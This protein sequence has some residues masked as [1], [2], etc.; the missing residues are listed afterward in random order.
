MYR[1]LFFTLLLLSC[2]FQTFGQAFSMI[3]YGIEDGLPSN[4]VN[5]I[6]RDSKGLLWFATDNGLARYNGTSFKVWTTADGLPCNDILSFQEDLYG[7]LWIALY[8]GELCYYK[9][10][11]FH[12]AATDTLLKKGFRSSFIINFHLQRDSSIALT[13]AESNSF[14]IFKNETKRTYTLPSTVISE[15]TKLPN[16]SLLLKDPLSNTAMLMDSTGRM[17]N[18]QK[19]KVKSLRSCQNQRYFVDSSNIFDDAGNM[20]LSYRKPGFNPR[21]LFRIYRS[22]DSTLFIASSAGLYIS[23]QTI[24]FRE[25]IIYSITQDMD[26]DYWVT[27]KNNG[28]YEIKNWNK[29]AQTQVNAYTRSC[30]HA[31]ADDSNLYFT[32]GNNLY[33]FSGTTTTCLL[34]LHHAAQQDY[35][36]FTPL[37]QVCENGDYYICYGADLIRIRDIRRAGREVTRTKI[38]KN[39]HDEPKSILE[40]DHNIYLAFIR[41]IGLFSLDK[42]AQPALRQALTLPIGQRIFAIDKAKNG[43]W[44]ATRDAIYSYANRNTIKQDQFSSFSFKWF[45]LYGDYLLGITHNDLVLLCRNIKGHP[46]A[47]TLNLNFDKAYQ[48]DSTHI[49]LTTNNTYQLLSL[50]PSGHQ[51]RYTLRIIEDA[52]I[53]KQAEYICANTKKC[54]F[55]AQGNIYSVPMQ[56]LLRK[57]APPRLFFTT[58]ND[59]NIYDAIDTAIS[60]AYDAAEH[61]SIGFESVTSGS[62]NVVYEYSFT[63]NNEQDYWLPA[64]AGYLNLSNA[65][66][67][68]YVIKIR[69]KTPGSDYSTPIIIRLQIGRPFWATWW[70]TGICF[71]VAVL[72]ILFIIV[73]RAKYIYSKKALLHE[74][75]LRFM[76]SE[77]KALN[78]LMNPHFIFNTL[79]SFKAL[80]NNN[81]KQA[82]NRYM[83]IFADLIRQNMHNV[84]QELISLQKEM[85]LVENYLKLE[86]LRFKEW[87]NYKIDIEEDLD[88][89]AIMIPPLMI[90][91]LVENAI[92]HGLIPLQSE[93]N[94]LHIKVMEV[95]GNLHVAIK[96]NGVGITRS[97]H[98]VNTGHQ[99]FGLKNITQRIEQLAVLHQI[100]ISLDITPV[101]ETA[102]QEKGTLVTLI[103]SSN[104][105]S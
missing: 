97:S 8:N 30:T 65:G 102:G 83:K 32:T 73:K 43:L 49:L 3:H 44:Y 75:E 27:D 61:I 71:V 37:Y 100:A 20:L 58:C 41:D 53:P 55:L 10:G 103:V 99:S 90:Q 7:R 95:D 82:A 22:L 85:D 74:N 1:L 24:A 42:H 35:K 78:A 101:F 89:E 81:D 2:R 77:Y 93:L 69:A 60:I 11:R 57:P 18:T 79:N 105:Q 94:Y 47:D 54:F 98:S 19:A 17:L 87:L 80:I 33:R 62:K 68:H 88:T 13:F 26:S 66:Y 4:R 31:F 48:L 25:H 92:K 46:E 34:N 16:G 84:S 39:E 21:L 51:P 23:G 12:S 64:L 86:Q 91:P 9:E 50:F 70:F 104:V 38:Q 96:D 63:K 45:R 5:E 14:V 76:R 6:Y 36:Q 28:V 52:F 15:I 67:G 59:Q 40:Y 56:E 72:F 29:G